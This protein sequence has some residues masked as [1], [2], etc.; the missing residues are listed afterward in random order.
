VT[1]VE[2]L[3]FAEATSTIFGSGVGVSSSL[4]E[5]KSTSVIDIMAKVN[6]DHFDLIV[7]IDFVG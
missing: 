6:K 4:Q 1:S 7:F 2:K 5:E 3:A